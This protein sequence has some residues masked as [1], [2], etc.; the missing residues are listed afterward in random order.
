MEHLG[1]GICFSLFGEHVPVFHEI[2]H[3]GV[4]RGH[5]DDPLAHQVQ[6]VGNAEQNQAD[7]H[8]GAGG[9]DLA[10]PACGDDPALFHG[11]EPHAGHGELPQ[12][13][14]G[15]HPAHHIAGFHEP[16]QG[17]HH[18][19]LVRQGIGKLAEVRHL[20]IMPGNVPVQQVR[21]AGHDVDG[22]GHIAA[23]GKAPVGHHQKHRDQEHPEQGQFVGCVH[24]H[25]SFLRSFTGKLTV[26][27]A[28]DAHT[29][30]VPRLHGAVG[31]EVNAAVDAGALGI[32]A[33][34]I[35]HGLAVPAVA[36]HLH[37]VAH[38]AVVELV[39]DLGLDLHH[40]LRPVPG[41]V[42]VHPVEHFRRWGPLLRGV[43]KGPHPL[44]LLL[45]QEV[46]QLLKGGLVLVGQ[47]GDEAGAQHHAGDTAAQASKQGLQPGFGLPPAHGLQHGIVAVLD[48]DVQVV[49]DLLLPGDGVNQL[50][51]QVVGVEI[52]QPDPVEGQ[53]AQSPQQL[54][55]LPLPVQVHAVAGNILGDDDALLHAVV[56]QGLGLLQNVLHPAGAVVAP[57]GGDH[58]IGAAVAAPLGDAEIG[59]LPGSGQHPGQ[60]LH[61]AV[62]IRKVAA[63][64]AVHHLLQGRHD[65]A[66]AAGAHD[67]VDL[68]Q[69]IQDIGLIPLAQAAG[70]ENLLNFPGVLQLGGGENGVNGLAF[71][72]VDKA[73]G[74]DDHHVA[75]GA[76]LLDGDAG[77]ETQGHHLLGV[78]PV[79]VAAQGYE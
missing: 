64:L 20:V 37:G 28:G 12:Q 1:P 5:Q 48:G 3:A 2:L 25:G 79:L 74:V 9:F 42:G 17:R 49:A 55:Q 61:R 70:D 41:L 62:D 22:Q 19:A 57:Q 35:A 59:V 13:H 18:Q 7:A 21:Q 60:L 11:D 15:Q 66:E 67:A 24:R 26:H 75:A 51:G 44:E 45:P 32:A 56:R 76:V 47:A 78:H 33:A 34:H 8:H 31:C 65:V 52:V 50:V 14:C 58:A 16:A 36:Q 43:G 54:R 4:H 40:Q 23:A 69:L 10:G 6:P 46:A 63:L 27:G 29:D 38:A 39:H 72:A 73:A 68:R 71:G 53:P 77:L 30:K